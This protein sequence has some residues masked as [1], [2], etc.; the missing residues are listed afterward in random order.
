MRFIKST[1]YRHTKTIDMGRSI[2]ALANA[3]I[4]TVRKTKVK[5]MDE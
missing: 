4:S 2:M 1:V 3:S 5:E